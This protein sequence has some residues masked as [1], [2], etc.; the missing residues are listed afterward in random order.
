MNTA[1]IALFLYARPIETERMLA[2]LMACDGFAASRAHVFADGPAS[3]DKAARVEAVR[4][5]ARR[6]L[7][8][9]AAYHF[10]PVN[11]GLARSIRDGVGQLLDR[12]GSVIVVEDDL[13]FDRRFLRFLDGA[14]HAYSDDPR[15]MQVSGYQHFHPEL[16]QLGAPLALPLSTTWGW[17]TWKRAWDDVDWQMQ[18]AEAALADRATRRRFNYGGVYDF[19]TM[20]ARQRTGRINSWGIAFYWSM[21]K[22]GRVAIHPSVALVRNNGVH[23]GG[24]HGGSWLR[25]FGAT[26]ARHAA[27]N[28]TVS[29]WPDARVDPRVLAL[30]RKAVRVENGG[31]AGRMVDIV[32]SIKFRV[33]G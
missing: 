22:A 19:T 27:M 30:S 8:E 20:V 15:V 2:S 26:N 31:L 9:E 14:L 4:T 24:S 23:G 5:L 32:K 17:A 25:R 3:S 16:A 33:F 18:G 21:F 11:K 28:F 1:P 29:D 12:F 7:G 6:M 13:E 10:S